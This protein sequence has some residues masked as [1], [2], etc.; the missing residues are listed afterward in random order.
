MVAGDVVVMAT[1]DGSV[2]AFDR[3][4]GER[5]WTRTMSDAVVSD[6]VVAGGY[7]IIADIAGRVTALD[8]DGETAWSAEV[9]AVTRPISSLPDGS[10]LVGDDAGSVHRLAVDGALLW[11]GNLAGSV[12]G[13]ARVTGGVIVLPT[14]SGL[15]G[16]ALD[17]GVDRWIEEAWAGA[18]AW[19][20]SSGVAV[21][22]GDQIA[23]V[24]SDGLVSSQTSLVEPDGAA[25][26]EV[27]VVGFSGQASL[28]TSRGALLPWPGIE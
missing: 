10:V 11:S 6:P 18:Q 3:A 23:Q 5:M 22:R 21:T 19:S 16:L 25:V 15:Q 17:T 24:S 4:T 20:H 8:T 13:P 14:T 27:Q 12:E 9:G 26:T 7:V 28:L 1:L 2:I